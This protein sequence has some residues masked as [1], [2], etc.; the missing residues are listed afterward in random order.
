MSRL[1]D[2]LHAPLPF[3]LYVTV[4]PCAGKELSKSAV[5]FTFPDN[6]HITHKTR[7]QGISEDRTQSPWGQQGVTILQTDKKCVGVR[8]G[9]T[10]GAQAQGRLGGLAGAEAGPSDLAS[11]ILGA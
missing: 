4:T 3:A 6:S 11:G 2:G 9:G 5:T 1:Q 7:S 10:G 8:D